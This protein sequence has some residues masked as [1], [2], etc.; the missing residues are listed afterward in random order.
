MY[1]F[2]KLKFNENIINFITVVGGR[3]TGLG[4][5]SSIHKILESIGFKVVTLKMM[6]K[7]IINLKIQVG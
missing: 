6:M 3:K 2:L 7:L 4:Y 5:T 1:S